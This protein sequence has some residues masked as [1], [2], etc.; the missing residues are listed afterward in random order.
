MFFVD[1]FGRKPLL[2]LGSLGM[3]ACLFGLELSIS[4]HMAPLYYLIILV[5]YNMFFA[6][7]QGTIIW[8]FL[9]ELFPFG[10][11]GAGQGYGSAVL[12]VTNTLLVLLYPLLQRLLPTQGLYLFSAMMILQIVVVVLWYPETK[13][14]ALGVSTT[15]S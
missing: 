13:G 11:R 12:W 15:E 8:I 10:V 7:S 2:L 14:R 5:A 9:S 1:K 3:A 4:H 6:F